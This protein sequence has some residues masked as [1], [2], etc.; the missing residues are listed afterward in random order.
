V[1]DFRPATLMALRLLIAF[2]PLFVYLSVTRGGVRR[3]ARELASI[4]R[5]GLALGLLSAAVPFT[6]VAWGETHIDSGVAGVA[7]ASVP[8]FTALLALRF[9]PSERPT[10]ARLVGIA[11]GLVGV[12]VL[13]G[14]DPGT[15]WW[16]VA[17]TLAVVLASLFYAAGGL[18]GQTQTARVSGPVLATA[19]TLYGALLLLPWG[20]AD[21]PSHAPA[22]KPVAS[23]VA[24]A[25]LGTAFAQLLLFHVLRLHGAARVALVTYLMPPFAIFYG[26]TV[27]DEPLRWSA[28]AG[29][30]LI[31]LGVALGSGVVVPRRRAALRTAP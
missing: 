19:V 9:K 7:Q 30:G 24:L 11:L 25:L 29:L 18:F 4:W 20:I 27:L 28:L 16:A 26:A 12:G 22:W 8:V 31:L 15:G 23:L 5:A 3:A 10:G 1:R 21:L 2:V 13:T 14:I 17:G 6:L